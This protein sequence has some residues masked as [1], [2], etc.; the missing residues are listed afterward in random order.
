MLNWSEYKR[1]HRSVKAGIHQKG[2]IHDQ[3]WARRIR[4]ARLLRTIAP[5]A[6]V[7]I[8]AQHFRDKS[9]VS[10]TARKIADSLSTAN[11][12]I[13]SLRG[14]WGGI[15]GHH[16]VILGFPYQPVRIIHTSIDRKA[17]GTGAAFALNE[18]A[19]CETGF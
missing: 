7:E 18:L 6:H 2:D 19:T 14:G 1:E 16:E 11:E 8:L 15:V 5:F 13:T 4:A 10:G 9:E 17:F 3:D 12:R